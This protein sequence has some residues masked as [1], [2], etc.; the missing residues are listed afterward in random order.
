M[1]AHIYAVTM[2]ARSR[3]MPQ[4]LP[5]VMISLAGISCF[6]YRARGLQ[7]WRF[8]IRYLVRESAE[9]NQYSFNRTLAKCKFNS[10]W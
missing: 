8:S 10:M 9:V 5:S 1:G 3:G 7:N 4:S 2:R 6:A